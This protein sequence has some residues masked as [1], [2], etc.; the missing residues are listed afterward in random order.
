[1][2]QKKYLLFVRWTFGT[3]VIPNVETISFFYWQCYVCLASN[4]WDS[5]LVY[6]FSVLNTCSTSVDASTSP[7]LGK[8]FI[9]GAVKVPDLDIPKSSLTSSFPVTPDS[10]WKR[11]HLCN[12][13]VHEKSTHFFYQDVR[14][15]CVHRLAQLQVIAWYLS[16]WAVSI[17]RHKDQRSQT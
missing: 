11:S 1:M 10:C 4:Y 9:E 14:V 5:V 7:F 6:A 13:L 16:F 2:Y 12:I 15:A 8:C 3:A 17:D